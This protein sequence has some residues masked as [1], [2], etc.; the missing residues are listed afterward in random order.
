MPAIGDLFAPAYNPT[1]PQSVP[2]AVGQVAILVPDNE[3]IGRA[4]RRGKVLI[5]VAAES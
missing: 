2:V 5:S 1:D 3:K 4:S